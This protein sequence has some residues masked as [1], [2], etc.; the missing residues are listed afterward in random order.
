MLTIGLNVMWVAKCKYKPGF[1]TR[2]HSHDFYHYIYITN[3]TG[4]IKI[5]NAEYVLQEKQ[6]YMT[7]MNV[8]HELSAENS[9][10]LSTIEIKFSLC[11]MSMALRTD[12]LQYRIYDRDLVINHFLDRIVEEALRKEPF[13]SDI[14]NVKFAGMLLE[15]LSSHENNGDPAGNDRED[16]RSNVRLLDFPASKRQEQGNGKEAAI[17]NS[18]E[19]ARSYI[20]ANMHLN[21]AL[22]TLARIANLD[23]AYFCRL[24]KN[25]Y[26]MPPIHYLNRIRLEK[27]KELLQYSDMT[28]TNIAYEVGFQSVHYFSHFFT[29]KEGCSPFEFKQRQKEDSLYIILNEQ[30]SDR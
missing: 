8:R 1:S 21:L 4:S 24:F 29:V 6:F 27:A 19:A 11:D 25:K 5:G 9:K 10:G 26:G 17:E 13:H 28:I 16:T 3:G 15:L 2:F 22:D 14:I 7:P 23:P 30:Y 18:I 12:R 20:Y